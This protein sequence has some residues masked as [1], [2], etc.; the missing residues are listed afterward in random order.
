MDKED[1]YIEMDKDIYVCVYYSSIQW[2][3]ILLSLKK[4][5]II[6]LVAT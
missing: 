5:E 1:L 3:G 6:P 2:N 4:T